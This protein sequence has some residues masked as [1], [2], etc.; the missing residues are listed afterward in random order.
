MQVFNT[1]CPRNCYST[2]SFKVWVDDGKI[3]RIDPQPLNLATPEGACLKGLSYIERA[4]SKDRILYPLKKTGNDFERI[5]WDEAL[6]TI[7]QKL[8]YYKKAYGC[9]SVLFYAASGMSGLLNGIG[10]NFWKLYGGAT[11][12]YGNLCW[13]AGLEAT[14]L[15]L[16]DNKHNVPWD[17]ENAKLIILWGKNPAETNIQQ[18]IPIEKA[19]TKGARLVVIDPR[20]TASSERAD[21]LLQPIPGTDG[22]LA[23]SIIKILIQKEQ[24]DKRFINKH[25]LGFDD[26]A[27]SLKNINIEETSRECG[28]PVHFIEKLASWIG[29]AETMTLIP[30]YGMQRFSNGGQTIRCL[31]ALQVI[32]GHIGLPGSCWHYADLQ[33]DIFSQPKEPENYYPPEKPDGIFRREIATA[34]LGEQMLSTKNPELKMAWVER[35]NPLSQNPDSNK[36]REAFRKLEFRVVVEQFMTD[37]ALEADIILPAKNMFEQ[38]DL[39]SCYWHPYIQLKQKVLE[40]AGEVK[41]ETEIYYLLAKKLGF[42]EDEI[43]MNFPGLSDQE[44]DAWLEHQISGYPELSLD[45]LRQ[46]P[47]LSPMLQEIA[48][49]DYHFPTPSGMIELYSTQA[50]KRW[51]VNPLPSYEKPIEGQQGESSMRFPFQLLS[52]NTKNRIHSQFGNLAVIKGITDEPYAQI[53]FGDAAQKGI[54]SNDTIRVFNNRGEIRIKAKTDASLR[55]GCISIANGFWHQEGASPN[56]LSLGRETDMGH[57]TAFHDNLVDYEKW[58]PVQ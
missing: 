15:T 46:G 40:P 11:T 8:Q 9:Y 35:G 37:T 13:P 5:S 22:I 28:I 18:M 58:E 21:L 3:I 48:F 10:T 36:V 7:S 42:S 51:G 31:L 26:F 49:S 14:R 57:G 19:Q 55:P 45:K 38:S 50:A 12:V 52:P 4:H 56:S 43:R 34:R 6:D 54:K 27:K 33:G 24:I 32:T 23:L 16:G 39:I 1:A 44:I 29:E 2:C 25:V 20:R 30:G 17:L 53:N 41:P 47:I